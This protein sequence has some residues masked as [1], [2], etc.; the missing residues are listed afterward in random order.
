MKIQKL[1]LSVIAIIA[2]LSQAPLAQAADHPDEPYYIRAYHVDIDVAEDNVLSIT[3]EIHVYFNEERHGIYR[4]IPKKNRI[5]RA[6]GSKDVTR[7]KI[8]NI[9][10]SDKYDKSS[11]SG[12]LKLQ[13]GDADVTLTGDK[14]YV[15]SYDYMLGKDVSEG[16]DEL[17]FNIIGDKWDTY[18]DNVSFNI[19]MPKEF[20][21]SLL[22]FSTGGYGFTGSDIVEYSVNGLEISGHLTEELEPWQALTVRLELSEGYFYFNM[23]AYIIKL[24]T[25][26]LIPVL[27]LIF[28]FIIWLKYGKDKKVIRTVEF[29]PPDNMSSIDVAYWYK[30]TLPKKDIIALLIEIANEG[31]IAIHDGSGEGMHRKSDY[32]IE[33]KKIYPDNL[34]ENKK[35]FFEGLFESGKD[36]VKGHDLEN[37]F[38]RTLNKI[39]SN[40]GYSGKVGRVHSL[41]STRLQLLCQV[42][43]IAGF[44]GNCVIVYNILGGM[45]KF[46]PFG[47]GAIILVAA[48][49][50]SC[51]VSKRTDESHRNLE[52]LTGFR[53]FLLTAEKQ[54]LEMLVHENP[55][56][57]YNI[58]PYAYVLGVSDEW[59]NKF[60]GIAMSAPEWYSGSGTFTTAAMWSSMNSTLNSAT[61]A[62]TSMPSQSSSGGG[63]GGGGGVS[64]GG[65]GGGGGG[66]W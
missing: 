53:M 2:V 32:S 41:K 31:Y 59:V 62:M 50:L 5:E 34:D 30:G 4:D 46:I 52:R 12:N 23:I 49:W 28:V 3:E 7:A 16:F 6:D 22:G 15:I 29:Y 13:I 47:I 48:F 14:E 44:V 55:K 38:Y 39:R 17:Y 33:R 42:L 37:K 1:I 54:K 43:S 24:S 10:C 40:Y 61:S 27:L 57:F 36:I 9:Y 45:E 20:D 35:L 58:L 25:M 26:V 65:S 11:G 51:Y 8:K 63:S 66:S 18:I 56:Y 19:T 21:E 64:G 60:E